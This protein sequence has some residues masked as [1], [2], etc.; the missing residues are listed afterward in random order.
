MRPEILVVRRQHGLLDGALHNLLVDKG[1]QHQEQDESE[2]EETQSHSRNDLVPFEEVV[3]GVNI[4]TEHGLGQHLRVDGGSG[5]VEAV[6][7]EA[8]VY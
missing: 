6:T 5:R 3:A 2:N 7:G 8:R 1:R 4:H